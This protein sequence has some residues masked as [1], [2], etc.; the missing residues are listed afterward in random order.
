MET[1]EKILQQKGDNRKTKGNRRRLVAGGVFLAAA[2]VLM[3]LARETDG[4]AEWY[5]TTVYPLI[6]G[7]LGRFFGLFPFSAVELGLYLLILAL[8]MW[9]VGGGILSVRKRC[10]SSFLAETITRLVVLIGVLVFLYAANCGVNYSR[11]PFS[12][13]AGLTAGKYTKEELAEFCAWTVEELNRTEASALR[14]EE[15]RDLAR[16]ARERLGEEYPDLAGYY[17]LPKLILIS[18]ILSVQGVT[19]VYSPF[20]VEANVN[21]DVTAYNIPST[22]CHELSHLRGFMREDEANYIAFLACLGS[23]RAEFR[24]SGLMMAYVYGMNALLKE[25]QDAWSAIRS[26]LSDHAMADLAENTAF[27][28]QYEGEVRKVHEKVNDT[29]LK[30]NRQTDGVK[31]YGRA[32]DLMLAWYGDGQNEE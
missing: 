4:F 26:E 14:P 32:L 29:Y 31:S 1:S 17:P 8:L 11:T 16:E 6:V 24:Y 12:V 15:A 10:V 22:M 7:S 5:A 28:K 19:G 20:T 30:L 25:D 13:K 2:A 18:E 23:D 27:W 9:F 21:A 3:L